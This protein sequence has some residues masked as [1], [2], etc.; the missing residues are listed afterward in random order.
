MGT[1]TTALAAGMTY[2]TGWAGDLQMTTQPDIVGYRVTW[3]NGHHND[4]RDGFTALAAMRKAVQPCSLQ[5]VKLR[6]FLVMTHLSPEQLAG[7]QEVDPDD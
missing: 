5:I 4:Y 2:W 7:L 6:P 1:R 3:N